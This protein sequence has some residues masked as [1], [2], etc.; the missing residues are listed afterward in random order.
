M[1]TSVASP[2]VYAAP[3]PA[4]L[5]ADDTALVRL[6]DLFVRLEFTFGE[7]FRRGELEAKEDEA[8]DVAR[9]ERVPDGCEVLRDLFVAGAPVSDEVMRARLAAAD[10][11]LL[12]SLGLLRE[13]DVLPGHSLGTLLV[14]PIAG[15]WLFADHPYVGVGRRMAPEVV[16]SP[17]TP[18]TQQFMLLTPRTPC[19]AM[20][21]LCAGSGVAA[22]AA[23]RLARVA[24]AADVTHRS[25]R[26]AELNARFNGAR[27]VE[28]V[29]GDLY[30]PVGGRTFDRILA[31]P[32]YMPAFESE[33]IF[34]DGGA[35]GEQ[36]TRRIFAG[37]PAHLRPGGRCHVVCLATD[38][39]DAP[40]EQRIRGWIGERHE[41]FDVFVLELTPPRDPT[42]YYAH[43]AYDQGGGF[44]DVEP[45]HRFFREHRVKRLVYSAI[46]VERHAAARAPWTA[47]R[48]KGAFTA[49]PQIEWALAWER[50]SRD[51][52]LPAQLLDRVAVPSPELRMQL[53][54]A[55]RADGFA[56]V[57]ATLAVGS[58]L[59]Y[60]VDCAPWVPQ[61]LE[62]AIV[63]RPVGEHLAGLQ[64]AGIVDD[65]VEPA[66]FAA[67][68]RD[69]VGAGVLHVEGLEPPPVNRRLA[70]VLATW[71]PEPPLPLSRLAGA[72]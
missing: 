34:R 61:F 27:N 15:L 64:Q 43:R 40:L 20:L 8:A 72:G 37:L 10:V 47:R 66:R 68:V 52:S 12:D 24:V 21:D 55:P 28:A 5:T 9:A 41:E 29:Q 38:R 63:R 54:Y 35:D 26:F 56:L 17:L 18:N 49:W 30:E 48:K 46:V 69:L 4:I 57:D 60:E 22:I 58:P 3:A 33:Y 11:A 19:D 7:L 59:A 51:A 36:I 2:V 14:C 1:A 62:R 16:Y 25:T 45:R 44:A 71:P 70:D 67:A 39:D 65:D 31:H 13:H 6:R 42:E 32:P 50:L 53:S 23:A